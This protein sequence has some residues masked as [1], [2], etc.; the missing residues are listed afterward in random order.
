[1]DPWSSRINCWRKHLEGGGP[2]SMGKESIQEN[3]LCTSVNHWVL[4][5]PKSF[6]CLHPLTLYKLRW[7]RET[8]TFLLLYR[9]GGRF[10]SGTPPCQGKELVSGREGWAALLSWQ[11]FKCISYNNESNQRIWF[12]PNKPN[13]FQHLSLCKVKEQI[14]AIFQWPPGNFQRQYAKYP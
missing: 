5:Y 11:L 6:G 9:P 10:M 13:Y 1:M 12:T 2:V 3:L 8:R 7:K 14:F 4:T